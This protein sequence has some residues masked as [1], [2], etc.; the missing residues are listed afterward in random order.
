MPGYGAATSFVSSGNV[1]RGYIPMILDVDL[2]KEFIR[3]TVECERNVQRVFATD[4]LGSS[5]DKRNCFVLVSG[6]REGVIVYGLQRYNRYL[7]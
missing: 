2:E 7:E 4:G 1:M 6:G 3:E 5:S